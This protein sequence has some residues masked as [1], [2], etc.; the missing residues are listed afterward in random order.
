MSTPWTAPATVLADTAE[1]GWAGIW[2]LTHAATRAALH[3]ADALPL[4][5]GL[6][7]IYAASDLRHAQDIL[8]RNRPD[9]PARCAAVDLGPIGSP[10]DPA[11][12]WSVLDE[13]TAAALNRIEGLLDTNLVIADLVALADVDAALRRAHGKISGHRS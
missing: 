9:L 12:R 8:E 2:T 13:L 11:A 3:L 7:V 6:D 5:D 1:P 4:I 10:G